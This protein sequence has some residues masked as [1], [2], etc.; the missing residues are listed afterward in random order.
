MILMSMVSTLFPIVA[1]REKK[2][3]QGTDN[4]RVTEKWGEKEH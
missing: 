3:C 2:T 4:K 1:D